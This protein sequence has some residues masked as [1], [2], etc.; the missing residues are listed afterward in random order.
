M[1]TP[2]QLVIDV[3]SAANNCDPK[4]IYRTDFVKTA[5]AMEAAIATRDAEVQEEYRQK[6]RGQI[7]AEFGKKTNVQN[8]YMSESWLAVAL[9]VA[10]L[11]DPEPEPS[12]AAMRVV[13][14][15]FSLSATSNLPE[16]VKW[17]K[18][19]AL[20]IDEEFKKGAANPNA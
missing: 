5:P 3:I 16:D 6:V 15:F 7:T 10:A 13:R 18:E 14:R 1:K 17:L 12:E 20:Q 19:K 9:G 11:R 2:R 8:R 4:N